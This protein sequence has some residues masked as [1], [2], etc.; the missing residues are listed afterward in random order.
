MKK[1]LF[2]SIL[3]ASIILQS[4]KE[5]PPEPP[6]PLATKA[7]Y[8]G[9]EGL[10]PSGIGTLSRYTP[11]GNDVEHNIFQKAN[12][13]NSGASQVSIT[14]DGDR[15]F[16]VSAA[17]ATV[18]AINT[19]TGIVEAKFDDF[20]SPRFVAKVAKDRYYISDWEAK[21]VRILN[22][23]NKKL[24]KVLPTGLGPERMLLHDGKMFIT[25]RG[26]VDEGKLKNDSIVTVYDVSTDTLMAS[27]R[28]GKNPNSLQLDS[29]NRLW[30]L[31]EG[32]ENVAS[33]SQSIPGDLRIIDVDSLW[34]TDSII[35]LDNS[36]RPEQLAVNK[37][38]DKL[39]Y[40]D[41]FESANIRVH[42]TN[43][44]IDR[45]TVFIPGV[46]Y[47]LGTD[48]IH[49][50]IYVAD[51]SNEPLAGFVSRFGNDATLI[52]RFQAGIKPKSFAFQ[53]NR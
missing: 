12:V 39:Y 16:I 15:L 31:S 3:S 46:F 8:I 18:Y 11:E 21:G 5:D 34:V 45:E 42:L 38:G 36:R 13:Y 6:E 47:G 9:N 28:V 37:G 1:Y 23:A 40:M 30:V 2:F 44:S 32:K 20:G 26:G 49:D 25:N 43:D 29:Q 51:K 22:M 10:F 52:I 7:V 27:I 24:G 41:N 50:E 17:D 48:L 4:C 19:T 14:V 35:F 53:S 33:P